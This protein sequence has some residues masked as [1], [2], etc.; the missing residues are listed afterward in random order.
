MTSQERQHKQFADRLNRI[1]NGGK[2]TFKNVLRGPTEAEMGGVKH[3]KT[4]PTRAERR[5]RKSLSV[6][7]N[8]AK[9]L[10][11]FLR[12]VAFL[13]V[14]FGLGV[15]AVIIARAVDI[16]WG[17]DFII[18]MLPAENP[19]LPYL[20]SYPWAV[21]GLVALLTVMALRVLFKLHS[22]PR[23]ALLTA[24]ALAMAVYEPAVLGAFPEPFKTIFSPGYV[25][26]T[27]DPEGLRQLQDWQQY[28][29]TDP[30]SVLGRSGEITD[31]APASATL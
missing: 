18:A 17:T 21:M 15:A 25:A 1:Q 13:P 7:P 27:A 12:E 3:K 10:G 30:L 31:V 23:M 4:K 5:A 8:F 6:G 26:A 14:A 9:R 19:A 20:D 11:R 16:R 28:M 22:L 29:P 2:H 24:G